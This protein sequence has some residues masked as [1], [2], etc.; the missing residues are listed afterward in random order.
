MGVVNDDGGR[1]A[2]IH[3]TNDP[4]CHDQSLRRS[5]GLFFGKWQISQTRHLGEEVVFIPKKEAQCAQCVCSKTGKN[6]A[7]TNMCSLSSTNIISKD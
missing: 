1:V 2:L 5:L 4:C 3:L 7:I 6:C